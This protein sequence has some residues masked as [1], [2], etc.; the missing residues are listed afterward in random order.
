VKRIPPVIQPIMIME[1]A[2]TS[3]T[4]VDN[5]FKRQY[6]PEDKSELHLKLVHTFTNYFLKIHFNIIRPSTPRTNQVFSFLQDFRLKFHMHF[7]SPAI[8]TTCRALLAVRDS[9]ALIVS[10][11]KYTQ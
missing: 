1:A 4:S 3:E 6:I 5:Y 9:N 8:R 7:S 2:R 10:D 11:E